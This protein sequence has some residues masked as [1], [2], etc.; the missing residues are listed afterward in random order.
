[1]VSSGSNVT[2]QWPWHIYD[3]ILTLRYA[4]VSSGSNVTL[5]WPWHIYDLILTLRYAMV[6]S[7]SNV[8][9]T[10]YSRAGWAALNTSDETVAV[11]KPVDIEHTCNEMYSKHGYFR[12]GKFHENIGKTFHVGVIFTK[13][14]LFPSWE[15]LWVLFSRG[16]IFCEEDKSAKTQKLPPHKNFH[17]YSTW[18]RNIY[19]WYG[20][21]L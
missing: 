21:T 13:P 7:G 4:M 9:G 1:M 20:C 17:V 18:K 14:L 16:G 2:L 10:K 3:L 11:S 5:Q 8:N 19:T 12:W 6:S 15:V